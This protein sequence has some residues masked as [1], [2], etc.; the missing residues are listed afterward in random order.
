MSLHGLPKPRHVCHWGRNQT[1]K[2]QCNVVA[3]KCGQTITSTE[4]QTQQH[5]TSNIFHN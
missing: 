1:N 5:S 2:K 3:S 4:K